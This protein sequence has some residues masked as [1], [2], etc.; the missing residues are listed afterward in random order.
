[1]T[2]EDLRFLAFGVMYDDRLYPVLS[3]LIRVAL[4]GGHLQPAVHGYV[5][6]A[7]TPPTDDNEVSAQLAVLCDDAAWPRA[8]ARYARDKAADGRRYPFYG[9][10]A[11]TVK[12]CTF[13]NR[14]PLEPPTH[15]GP[16]NRAPSILMVQAD[17][18]TA[19]PASG[20]QHLHRLL[21]RSRMVTLR[22]AQK[23]IV[24]AVYGSSCVD[25]TVSAYLAQGALPARD[26]TCPLAPGVAAST[27][28]AGGTR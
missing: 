28:A 2:G 20:A 17:L 9:A 21:P 15:I 7:L 12:P 27:T 5:E 16:G 23:H 3:D 24:F 13:W 8:L 11:S 25:T 14:R 10:S 22:G 1:L 4:Q 18:D 26:I 19:T 6:Q